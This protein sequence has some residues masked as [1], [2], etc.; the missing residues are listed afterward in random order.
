MAGIDSVVRN[1]AV[2]DNRDAVIS[3]VDTEDIAAAARPDRK[4]GW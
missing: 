4:N 1:I 3:I 2:D